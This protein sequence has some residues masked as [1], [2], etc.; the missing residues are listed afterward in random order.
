VFWRSF[1]LHCPLWVKKEVEILCMMKYTFFRD[2]TSRHWAICPW[3]FEIIVLCWRLEIYF[4]VH[5]EATE[6]YRNVG[7]HLPSNSTAS[8]SHIKYM[9]FQQPA[10]ATCDVHRWTQ[11]EHHGDEWQTKLF[12]VKL[13]VYFSEVDFIADSVLNY[14]RQTRKILSPFQVIAL[15]YKLCLREMVFVFSIL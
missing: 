4:T 13:R 3:P 9:W 5:N 12:Q 1:K 8:T 11:M 7:G 14:R 2:T 15:D 10:V 6:L